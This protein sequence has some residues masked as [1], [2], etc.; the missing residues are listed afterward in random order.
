MIV[1]RRIGLLTDRFGLGVPFLSVPGT[2]GIM[3]ISER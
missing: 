3:Q 2:R 1:E